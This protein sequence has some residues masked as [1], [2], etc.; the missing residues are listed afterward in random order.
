MGTAET[1][2]LCLTLPEGHTDVPLLHD[3][4]APLGRPSGV[5]PGDRGQLPPEIRQNAREPALGAAELMVTSV[6]VP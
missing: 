5:T 1:R 2:P 3:S 6:T 4:T